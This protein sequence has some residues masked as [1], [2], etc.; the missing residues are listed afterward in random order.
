MKTL[1]LLRH[2]KSDWSE[3]AVADH[4]RPLNRRGKRARSVVAEHVAGWNVDLVVCSTTRHAR[5]S[6]KPVGRGVGMSRAVRGGAV[7]HGHLEVVTTPLQRRGGAAAACFSEHRS[8]LVHHP[9]RDPGRGVLD[10]AS[11]EREVDAGERHP[12]DARARERDRDR[13]TRRSTTG[14]IRPG[15]SKRSRRRGPPVH[16]RAASTASAAATVRPHDG[17]TAAG[18]T[19]P[20]AGSATM[21]SI[22]AGAHDAR[23]SV[24]ASN[25]TVDV[26]VDRHREAQPVLIVGVVA[27]EV[28]PAGRTY[29]GHVKE[30][31]APRRYPEGR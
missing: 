22:F 18:P 27:D 5:Q 12:C 31:T 30:S 23:P 3:P 25:R 8:D 19:C 14:R 9:A 16:G 29:D 10:V 17:E 28:H 26:A 15:G 4:D 20:S 13:R 2:A 1:H 6:A 21:P 24:R 7:R 11:S